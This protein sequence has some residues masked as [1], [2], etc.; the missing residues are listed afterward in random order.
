M[1]SFIIL[2][3]IL[4]CFNLIHCQTNLGKI[5]HVI[6]LMLENRSFD[7][8]LGFL[9]KLN[10]NIDGC[11]PD[12]TELCSNPIDPLDSSSPKVIVDDE[13]VYV[14]IS[15][16]HSISGTTDQIY[17]SPDGTDPSMKGFIGSYEKVTEGG[18]NIMKC[19]S[20]EHLPILANL[21]MEYASFDSWHASVPG[22]TMVN[23][24]FAASGTSNGMGTNDKKQIAL[25]LPQKTMFK[26]LLD[27]GLDY[28]IYFQEVPCTV[29]FKELRRPEALKKYR[30][31][32]KLFD[33]LKEGNLPE[34]SWLEPRY[35]DTPFNSATDQH[36]D[37]D[38]SA[39][40]NLIKEVYEALRES[41]LWNESALL[42]TYDEHG[43]F[44]DHVSPP[45]NIPS[46]DGKNSTDDPFDFTRLGKN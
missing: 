45:E 29:M 41:S 5:K 39:G 6:V 27:M 21:S 9:K 42:I 44:F 10:S 3:I 31:F 8:M 22:P 17:G 37:H 16:T 1:R 12:N 34:F 32:P 25:G 40:E 2:F 15:P 19:F 13:A 4:G 36:P 11:L 38:V 23:R 24:A 7:H 18:Q 28:R 33:D 30:A 35:Y 26:Q 46:P 14:Q 43:G 20:P